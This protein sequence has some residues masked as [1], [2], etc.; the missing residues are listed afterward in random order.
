MSKFDTS[1]LFLYEPYG[2]HSMRFVNVRYQES[3]KGNKV[4]LHTSPIPKVTSLNL[5]LDHSQLQKSQ[6]GL[7]EAIFQFNNVRVSFDKNLNNTPHQLIFKRI[8]K[9]NG[10]ISLRNSFQE[11]RC[12]KILL[13]QNTVYS[14]I[15][16]IFPLT[17]I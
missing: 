9:S 3:I 17:Y 14:S 10:A 1:L 13:D 2:F 12:C 6:W 16:N 4:I 5:Y 11:I 8:R 7:Q 15:V